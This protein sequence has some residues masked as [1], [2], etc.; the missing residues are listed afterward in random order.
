MHTWCAQWTRHLN[1]SQTFKAAAVRRLCQPA[2]L[3][4]PAHATLCLQAAA[5][6][7]TAAGD[8]PILE[9]ATPEE[10]AVAEEHM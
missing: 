1:G 8:E 7:A 10:R 9:G 5:A 3:S 4:L 2:H 6:R